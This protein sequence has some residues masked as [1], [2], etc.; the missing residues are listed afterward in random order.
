MVKIEGT[1]SKFSS[2]TV[3]LYHS[4]CRKGED[5]VKAISGKMLNYPTV[6]SVGNTM[7]NIVGELEGLTQQGYQ[8]I[9]G[10]FSRD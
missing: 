10:C 5:V 1:F 3:S 6:M 2:N 8:K 4:A 9:S 7:E